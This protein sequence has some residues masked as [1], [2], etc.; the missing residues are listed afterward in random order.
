MQANEIQQRFSQIE[1]TVHQ[2]ARQCQTAS[3]VP[4][5][6]KDSIQQLDQK[7]SQ[8]RSMMQSQD[9]NQIRQ[10]VDDLEELGDRAKDA[11]EQSGN[12]DG[13][14]RDAIMQAHREL[15][16]FKHQLH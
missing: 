1:N 8:A 9:E 5:D 15:S 2:L 12:I 14:L 4:M 11:C 16:D 3:A 6:V 10:C 7:T 13:G